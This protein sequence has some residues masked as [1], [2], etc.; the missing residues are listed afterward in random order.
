MT[1]PHKIVIFVVVVVVVDDADWTRMMHLCWIVFIPLPQA[2]V[3]VL[4]AATTTS[5]SMMEGS[6][7]TTTTLQSQ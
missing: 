5:T 2:W 3:T 6:T 7:M 4:I 1:L